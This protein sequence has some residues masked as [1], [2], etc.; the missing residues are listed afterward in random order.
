MK[1]NKFLRVLL[2]LLTLAFLLFA[3]TWAVG[4]LSDEGFSLD[5]ARGLLNMEPREV[6]EL[7]RQEVPQKDEGHQEYYFKLLDE[8]EQRG[9]REMLNGIRERKEEFYLSISDDEKVDRAYHA[10]LKDHP[11]LYWVHNREQVY[12]TTFSRGDY[13]L[14]SPGYTYTQ[15]EMAEIDSALEQAY[16]EVLSMLPEN[17]D[18]YEKA[19]VVYTYLIDSVEYEI[20]QDDQSIAGAFWKHSAVCAGYAGGAQYLLE[21]LGVICIYVE[22][23]VKDS[24]EGHAWN[25]VQLDGQ[26]YYLDATNG[27]Q[28][29]FLE[30]DAVTMV[31]HKTTIYDYLCPFPDEYEL[32]YTPSDEFDLPE[33]NAV[34]KNFYVLNQGCFSSYNWQEIYDYC[35]M[36]LNNGAAVVRFKFSTQEAFD[37]AYNEWIVNGSIQSLA[38][39]YMQLYGLSQVEYH[40]GILEDLK[41][42]YFMF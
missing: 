14:F 35:C 31:E 32:N 20:S 17:A 41:T 18:D 40:Y 29:E 33:M 25:I 38:Q 7:R 34:D 16:Q 21:R 42:M 28:P 4:R 13:C 3:G 15:E 10:L 37:A 11:E 19:R 24:T 22:G 36:R 9:Y 5:T 27:D 12:K 8:E 6:A 30:G 39:Y 2:V 1:K 26:Y 23:S